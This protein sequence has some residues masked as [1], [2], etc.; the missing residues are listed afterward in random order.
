LKGLSDEDLVKQAIEERAERA[1]T[2]KMR[3]KSFDANRLWTDYA[4]TNRSSGKT[5]RVALRGWERGGVVL[6]MP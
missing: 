3:L 5:Y 6:H 4:V 2:E 1:Q